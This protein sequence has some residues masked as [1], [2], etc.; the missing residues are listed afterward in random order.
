MTVLALG[1]VVFLGVSRV[2]RRKDSGAVWVLAVLTIVGVQVWVGGDRLDGY[3][4]RI[5]GQR[6]HLAAVES[7][8]GLTVSGDRGASDVFVEGAGRQ[9]LAT[10]HS[11][12][13]GAVQ[14]SRGVGRGGVV[15]VRRR[16]FTGAS[17]ELLGAASL[18][19]GDVIRVQGP[20]GE[21]VEATF[22]RDRS[23]MLQKLGVGGTIDRV[24][25]TTPAAVATVPY[26]EGSGWLGLFPRRPN[27]NWTT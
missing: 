12:E 1:L 2:V 25:G 22:R 14:V 11:P 21:S 23:T 16:S 9:P 17:W 3:Q 26:P 18:S 13:D 15:A 4:L 10:L 27:V 7:G 6:F 24:S 19:P 8:S 20:E 5:L